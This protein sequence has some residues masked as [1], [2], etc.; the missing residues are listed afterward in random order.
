MDL[1]PGAVGSVGSVGVL[2]GVRE[3]AEQCSGA[4]YYFASFFTPVIISLLASGHQEAKTALLFPRLFLNSSQL[5][6]KRRQNCVSL[7]PQTIP[8][9]N[10]P[11]ICLE[12]VWGP[13]ILES[14]LRLCCA[15]PR[16]VRAA[17]WL[18]ERAR[19]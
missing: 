2:R 3:G 19:A 9:S 14:P 7:V 12:D 18:W 1:L 16:L 15:T 6:N 13:Y 5:E 17:P 8:T 10:Y 11:H 4:V